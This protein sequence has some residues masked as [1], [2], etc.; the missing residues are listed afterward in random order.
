[1]TTIFVKSIHESCS[2]QDIEKLF[3]KAP[4]GV[5]KILL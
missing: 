4:G 2:L 5:K 3:E 1:M